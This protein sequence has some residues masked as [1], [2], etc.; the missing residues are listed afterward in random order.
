MNSVLVLTST[1]GIPRDLAENFYPIYHVEKN[2]MF[3][4]ANY[5]MRISEPGFYSVLK[6]MN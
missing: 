4:V 3:I 6:N 5:L 1:D 2:F